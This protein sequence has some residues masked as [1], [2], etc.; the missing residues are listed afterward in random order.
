[1]EVALFPL[2]I[3]HAFA[4]SVVTLDE[5]VLP[6][7]LR[8]LGCVKDSFPA[9]RRRDDGE[10]DLLEDKEA[11]GEVLLFRLLLEVDGLPFRLSG[12]INPKRDTINP[13]APAVREGD[14]K[15]KARLGL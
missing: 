10:V 8:W 6:A 13:E 9:P 7:F 2:D 3:G 11:V 4:V 1:M 15:A 5:D 12:I 14:K